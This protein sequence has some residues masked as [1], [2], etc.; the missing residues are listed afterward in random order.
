MQGHIVKMQMLFGGIETTMS[1]AG[2]SGVLEHQLVAFVLV[3][4]E[5]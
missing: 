4:A 3:V 1:D 5:P 2:Q